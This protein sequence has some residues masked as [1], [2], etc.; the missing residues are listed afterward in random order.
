MRASMFAAVS[1]LQVHA[2]RRDAALASL[3]TLKLAEDT[4][5]LL[6]HNYDADVHGELCRREFFARLR[7]ARNALIPTCL[8][9]L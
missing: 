8:Q 7:A 4:R 6:D 2:A 1:T 3:A 9:S 5:W